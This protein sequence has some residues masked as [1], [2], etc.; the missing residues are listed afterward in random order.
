MSI[1]S[2]PKKL[3]VTTLPEGMSA[4]KP[5]DLTK[6]YVIAEGQQQ[7]LRWVKNEGKNLQSCNYIGVIAGMQGL[8]FSSPDIQLVI[9]NNAHRAKGNEFYEEACRLISRYCLEKHVRDCRHGNV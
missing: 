8:S 5:A 9:L 6:Y 2:T 4:S 1:K 3:L 7:F